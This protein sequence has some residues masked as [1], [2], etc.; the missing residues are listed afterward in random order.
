MEKSKNY[1]V[2]G[3]LALVVSLVAVSLAYAG[4]T[5]TLNING[6]GTVKSVKWDVHF[7]NLGNGVT[8]GTGSVVTAPTIKTGSTSI[9]DY[10]VQLASPGDSVSFSFDVVNAGNFAAKLSGLT[11]GSPSCSSSNP[12]EATT[13]C[14]NLTYKLYDTTSNT[15]IT[16]ADNAVIAAKTGVRH[17][18]IVLTYKSTTTAAQLP[19]ADVTV[20]GLGVSLTYTQDGNA[21]L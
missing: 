20:S 8:T 16:A 14:G 18:K 13:V 1:I 3:I 2:F 4:F 15:E 10:V 7:A 12:S 5:Q 21:V 11:I 17:L 19:T 9:G 6:S